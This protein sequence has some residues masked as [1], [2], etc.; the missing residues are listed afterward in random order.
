MTPP[1]AHQLDSTKHYLRL[2]F[3][4]ENQ[5]QFYI[6]KP[7]EDVYDLVSEFVAVPYFSPLTLDFLSSPSLFV[8]G[9]PS[10]TVI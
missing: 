2:K 10:L 4:I 3:L 8:I 1:Q 6:P 7:E 5:V 9:G